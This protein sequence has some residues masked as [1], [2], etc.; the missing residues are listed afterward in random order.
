M[1]EGPSMHPRTHPEPVKEQRDLPSFHPGKGGGMERR[2]GKGE[3][4]K[5]RRGGEEKKG[6]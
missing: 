4:R 2:E 6:G 5:G 3:E 1:E